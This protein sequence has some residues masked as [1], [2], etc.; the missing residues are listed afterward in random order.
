MIQIL[1][2]IQNVQVI[3]NVQEEKRHKKKRDIKFFSFQICV[4]TNLSAPC[5]FVTFV[6]GEKFPIAEI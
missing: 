5:V 2:D 1:H 4:V 6:F 3:Q